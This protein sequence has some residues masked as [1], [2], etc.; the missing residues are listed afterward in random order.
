ML[1]KEEILKY[2][3]EDPDWQPA[4]DADPE[5][6]DL[7]DEVQMTLVQ[8]DDEEMEDDELDIE[9][10]ADDEEDEEDDDDD[11]MDWGDDEEDF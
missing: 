7:Y 11:D 5:E 3:K 9:L 8:N 2:L 10:D 1:S 6:W 4:D